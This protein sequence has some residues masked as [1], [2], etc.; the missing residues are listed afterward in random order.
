MRMSP[1]R[2]PWESLANGTEPTEQKERR[3]SLQNIS[4]ILSFHQQVFT[5]Y[6][7]GCG[8]LRFSDMLLFFP[9]EYHRLLKSIS[10][11][12]N[13]KLRLHGSSGTLVSGY[14]EACARLTAHVVDTVSM[15]RYC[16]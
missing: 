5:G 11:G 12:R 15:L 9:E 7:T 10:L 3:E 1:G 13:Y 4:H 16:Y 14:A 8:Q 6:S 2:H